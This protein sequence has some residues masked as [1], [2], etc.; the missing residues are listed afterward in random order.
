VGDRAKIGFFGK[1]PS[2]GDFVRI[3]LSRAFASAWDHWLQTVMPP[4]R[5]ALGPGWH[6]AWSKMPAWRFSFA[7]GCCGA[8]PASGVW[9]PSTDQVGRSFPLLIAAECAVAND[10]F[11]DA[12]E[13]LGREAISASLAPADL[14]QSLD[15]AP[16]P[17]PTAAQPA[18]AI[19]WWRTT[20]SSMD[21]HC[22]DTWPDAEM[23]LKALTL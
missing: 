9:L 11:L 12:A 1:L 5:E 4:A 20:A 8:M 7:A 10:A 17:L 2:R 3:G 22:S 13:R 18:A 23:F 19:H 21:D 6:D 14:L 15:A 16:S